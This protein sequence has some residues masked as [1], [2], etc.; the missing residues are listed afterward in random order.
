MCVCVNVFVS[1]CVEHVCVCVCVERAC[2]CV[3]R[4]CVY[5][6][7]HEFSKAFVECVYV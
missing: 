3:E 6:K 4:V 1:V 2:V 7:P 5:L